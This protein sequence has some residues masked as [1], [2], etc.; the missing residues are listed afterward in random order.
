MHET[1][2]KMSVIDRTCTKCA[3]MPFTRR[4]E[5]DVRSIV[6]AVVKIEGLGAHAVPLLWVY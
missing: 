2:L 6:G 3:H 5:S 1:T 4:G